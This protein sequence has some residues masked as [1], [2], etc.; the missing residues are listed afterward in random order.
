GGERHAVSLLDVT[1]SGPLPLATRQLLDAYRRWSGAAPL[2]PVTA[3]PAVLWVYP[4]F[5]SAFNE[6][7]RPL[8]LTPMG[9]WDQ[10]QEYWGEPGE[11]LHPLC[12]RVIAAGVRPCFEMEQVLPGVDDDDW[13]ND[14]I[15]D[16]AEL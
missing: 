8:A 10:S 16:A 13:D 9:D 12:E 5:A 15:A 2:A 3:E 6:V 1:A 11:P 7:T 4:R 14:P